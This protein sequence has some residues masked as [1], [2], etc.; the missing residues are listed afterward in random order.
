MNGSLLGIVLLAIGTG[1]L[2]IGL[3]N[4]AGVPPRFLQFEAALVLYPPLILVCL[5]FGTAALITGIWGI[6]H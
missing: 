2:F 1:L 6:A 3:P 5:A 4:K